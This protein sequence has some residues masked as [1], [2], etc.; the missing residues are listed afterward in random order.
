MKLRLAVIVLLLGTPAAAAGQWT[1]TVQA[2]V[3]MDRLGESQR[4]LVDGSTAMASAPG[5]APVVGV[6]AS[7][8]LGENFGLDAGLAVSQNRSWSG[9]VA[10]PETYFVKRTVFTSAAVLWRPFG[11]SDRWRLQLGLGP[12]A[13]S[14]GGSGESLLARQTDLGAVA[15]VGGELGIG[16]RLRLGVDVYNYR[17][18]SRFADP[19]SLS[20][21]GSPAFSS[22]SRKRSEWLVLPSIRWAF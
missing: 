9:S 15:T 21:V 17:F 4:L 5:E 16:D 8:W 3:H 20:L 7:Y 18:S 12:A 14:H 1:I 11:E 6:R 22:G 19:E 13:I 2:G 10:T